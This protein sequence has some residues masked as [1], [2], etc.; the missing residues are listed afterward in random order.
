MRSKLFSKLHI[1]A[2]NEH[3]SIGPTAFVKF[4]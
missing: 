4:S 3:S 2:K 1:Q